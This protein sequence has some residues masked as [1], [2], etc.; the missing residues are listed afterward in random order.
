MEIKLPDFISDEDLDTND[1]EGAVM[2]VISLVA[3]IT[4]VS[5]I[6]AVGV[7]LKDRIAE[8]AGLDSESQN[9]GGDWY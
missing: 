6:V 2:Q 7:H 1:A 5:A 4:A 3:G 9:S 8:V